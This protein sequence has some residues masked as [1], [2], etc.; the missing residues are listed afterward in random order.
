MEEQEERD[1][2]W[3]SSGADYS[4]KAEFKTAL[5][6]M[7]LVKKCNEARATEMKQ[8]FWNNKIDKQGNAVRIWVEDQ[9]KVYI[10]T[11]IALDNFLHS[12]CLNDKAYQSFVIGDDKES[13]INKELNELKE[14]YAYTIFEFDNRSNGL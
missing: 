12:E 6:A 2:D 5:L 10:N 13:G 4:Q 9:R 8:G 14:K 3:I 1:D 11:V 7:E